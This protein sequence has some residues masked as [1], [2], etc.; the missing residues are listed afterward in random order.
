MS[1]FKKAIEAAAEIVSAEKKVQVERLAELVESQVGNILGGGY[2]QYA[3]VHAKDKEV[4][5]SMQ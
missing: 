3:A 2:S 4:A 5:E 1:D